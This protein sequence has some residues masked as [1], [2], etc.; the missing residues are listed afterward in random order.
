[1]LMQTLQAPIGYA[2]LKNTHLPTFHIN[3]WAASVAAK[4]FSSSPSVPT[5]KRSHMQEEWGKGRKPNSFS[6]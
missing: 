5:L 2:V 1:M 4:T 3:V 6:A